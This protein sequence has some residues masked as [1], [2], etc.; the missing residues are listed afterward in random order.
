MA[1]G[2]DALTSADIRA[3]DA[4]LKSSFGDVVAVSHPVTADLAEFLVGTITDAIIAPALRR[5]RWRSC[6]VSAAAGS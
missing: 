4:D 6:P 5:A 2:V 1:A 3:R